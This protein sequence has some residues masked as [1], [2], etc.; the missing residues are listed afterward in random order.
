MSLNVEI[1]SVCSEQVR[2]AAQILLERSNRACRTGDADLAFDLLTVLDALPIS[3]KEI[4]SGIGTKLN[5]PLLIDSTARRVSNLTKEIKSKWIKI[6]RAGGQ[7]DPVTSAP[8]A[9]LR[10][11]G[12]AVGD[13]VLID[14]GIPENHALKPGSSGTIE[15]LIG[16][17]SLQVKTRNDGSLK[18][19]KKWCIPIR[20][21]IRSASGLP[22]ATWLRESV[23]QNDDERHPD[24]LVPVAQA[25]SEQGISG[26][27]CMD[28]LEPDL[29]IKALTPRLGGNV[30]QLN[31]V[32][33][34]VKRAR[35]ETEC[36][37]RLNKVTCTRVEGLV[38]VAQQSR[39]IPKSDLTLK[40][41]CNVTGKLLPRTVGKL[42]SSHFSDFDQARSWFTVSSHGLAMQQLEDSTMRSYTSGLRSWGKFVDGLALLKGVAIP[43]FPA[44]PE[45]VE[46]WQSTFDDIGTASNYLS[47]L[48]KAHE[49][50]QCEP[51]WDAT[52]CTAIVQGHLRVD[53]RKARPRRYIDRNLTKRL[54]DHFL[55]SD[56]QEMAD[57][58]ALAYFGA[59]R[60][61]SELL[62]ATVEGPHSWWNI[63]IRNTLK[64]ILAKRKNR[65]GLSTIRREC[66][67]AR[68]PSMCP[69]AIAE[70]RIIAAKKHKSTRLFTLSY[71]NA[72]TKLRKACCIL[73]E[74]S[75]EEFT[76]HAFRRGFSQDLL[77]AN[78]PL[79][80]ILDA[81][82]W[83]STTFAWYL[84][85]EQ[86]DA[87]AVL[88]AAAE[89]SGDE[90]DD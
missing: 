89:L 4:E 67:C 56:D 72:Q 69:H 15:R 20:G 48:K 9:P 64:V 66:D 22:L 55:K 44:E 87:K 1:R 29:V 14:D 71:P 51:K 24:I 74:P 88:Q 62:P 57:L 70:K 63:T 43:H 31:L 35:N 3:V 46:W 41:K 10:E 28:Q 58:C 42:I 45:L 68:N 76:F 11:G 34:A 78:T 36:R 90:G 39:N 38:E 54:R 32:G 65:K 8:I 59:F 73:G 25:F 26:P 80:D 37:P 86:I 82:D 60:V 33:K 81:C 79:R 40:N 61:Q 2:R 47:I 77:K 17:A 30:P 5:A 6:W 23:A 7:I 52:K 49:W 21:T 19:D 18:V 12:Y 83:K 84:S 85:R 13:V 16:T 27:S 75:P 53:P 50:L